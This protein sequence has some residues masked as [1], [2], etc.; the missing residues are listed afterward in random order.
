MSDERIDKIFEGLGDLT[1]HAETTTGTGLTPA[2]TTATSKEIQ[3]KIQANRREIKEAYQNGWQDAMVKGLEKGARIR[4][5]MLDAMYDEMEKAYHPDNVNED[6]SPNWDFCNM[7]LIRL[8]YKA[9]TDME[10]YLLPTQPKAEI[11]VKHSGQVTH[12]HEATFQRYLEEI[13][14]EVIDAEVLE[15]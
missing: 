15:D 3:A 11:D 4:T 14:G 7:D 1:P 8:G 5:K 10:K 6:G 9:L 2:F 12:S 13:R